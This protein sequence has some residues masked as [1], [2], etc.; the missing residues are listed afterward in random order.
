MRRKYQPVR[1][2]LSRVA[3]P[4]GLRST[5]P[6]GAT[7]GTASAAASAGNTGVLGPLALAVDA[8]VD[9]MPPHVGAAERGER[10]RRYKDA[11]HGEGSHGRLAEA[12]DLT[13]PA[14]PVYLVPDTPDV[15]D[16]SASRWLARA[17]K[18]GLDVVGATVG[19]TLAAPLLAVLAV[20]VRVGSPG[21]V[22]FSQARVGRG[23]RVFRCYKL[24]TMR[25]DAEQLLRTDPELR[26]MYERHSFKVP[27]T[28][29]HR[30]TPIGRVLRLTSCDE[31]P[32]LWNVLRGEMSLVGPRPLVVRELAHYAGAD[33]DLLLSVRPGLTGAWAVGGRSRVGYPDRARMELD[34][35]RAW[36]PLRDLAIL[37]RTVGVVLARRGAS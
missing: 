31:L 13:A 27:C 32:Q 36:T 18:R 21:P 33:R 24:R 6:A 34:Y 37:A 14:A 20:V 7:T 35:V 10:A 25:E 8:M 1:A 19:L 12:P 9:P 2:A 30:V 5:G 16:E 11:A 28:A 4:N 26:A 17:S 29:D 15:A 23:G 22:I 3:R